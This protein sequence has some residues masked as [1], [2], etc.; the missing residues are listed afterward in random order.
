MVMRRKGIQK[1]F[2]MPMMLLNFVR[3]R[4]FYGVFWLLKVVFHCQQVEA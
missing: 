4:G 2:D 1:G 3:K